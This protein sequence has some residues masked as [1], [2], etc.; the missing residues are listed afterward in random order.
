MNEGST[1]LPIACALTAQELSSMRDGLL[2]GLLSRAV[3]RE[4]IPGGLRW[5]LQSSPGLMKDVGAMINAEHRCCP[6]LRF[7]VEV[8]TK[9]GPVVLEVTGPDGTE[10]FL[11][12]LLEMTRCR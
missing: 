9:D 10:Q 6:F 7:V 8:E 11:S 5:Q 1:S 12:T 3:S 2:P 4:S